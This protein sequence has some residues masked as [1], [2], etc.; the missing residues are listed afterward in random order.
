[1][2]DNPKVLI[3]YSVVFIIFIVFTLLVIDVAIQPT[4]KLF[5]DGGVDL[6]YLKER[7]QSPIAKIRLLHFFD[8]ISIVFRPLILSF[9]IWLSGHLITRNFMYKQALSLVLFGEIAYG[10]GRILNGIM[11]AKQQSIDAGVSLIPFARMISADSNTILYRAC[12]GFDIFRLELFLFWEITIIGIGL[13]AILNYSTQ[14]GIK[15]AALAV[16]LPI[17]LSR[18]ICRL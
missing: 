15:N 2:K 4:V 6:E 7:G 13:S 1:M 10:Y 14:K 9:F 5:R 17:L 3:P 11:I 12:S 16:A 8:N 18:L